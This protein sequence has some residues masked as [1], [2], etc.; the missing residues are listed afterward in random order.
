MLL[1]N[2]TQVKLTTPFEELV[3]AL[4]QMFRA[5]CQMPKRHHHTVKVPEEADATLLLMPAWTEG[6]YMGVKIVSVFPG[7][8]S[9]ALPS[10]SGSYLLSSARTGANLAMIDGGELTARRTAASSALASSYLSRRDSRVLLVCSTG[11]LS[12][13]MIA[14]HCSQ[15]PIEEVLIWGRDL[16]KAKATAL[17]AANLHPNVTAID[18]LETAARRADIISCAT[19]SQEPLIKGEWLKPGAHL[20]LVGAFTPLMRESD[21]NAVLRSS[22]FVDTREGA[23]SEGGDL[24]QPLAAG[25]IARE[26]VRADLFDLALGRH[27]GRN[28]DEEITLFKSVG[29]ALEDLAAAIL[30]FEATT[31]VPQSDG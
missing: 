5:N 3:E 13:N 2:E 4:R 26:A 9:R 7:N 29:A 10:V 30:T 28:S 23:L 31:R 24:V 21:D 18:D 17:L 12:L 6:H 20:D 16:E 27:A 1:I 14:A 15:R 25:I 8:V 22:I 19:L 11:R